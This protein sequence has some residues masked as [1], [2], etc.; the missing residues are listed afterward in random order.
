MS[1]HTT[2]DIAV[3]T[4]CS[5]TNIATAGRVLRHKSVEGLA[6]AW[7]LLTL[8]ACMSWT[9]YGLWQGNVF[10]V[11]TS[12]MTAAC[13]VVVL[14]MA[15]RAN[16]AKLWRSLLSTT[17]FLLV[18]SGMA[19]V[20]GANG[21]GFAGLAL[22]LINRIPQ[23]I[24]SLRTPGGHAVSLLGNG[25]DA[26]Q[27]LLWTVIAV[28]RYDVW[29]AASSLYCLLSAMF[30]VVRAVPKRAGVKSANVGSQP[31]CNEIFTLHN[32]QGATF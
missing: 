14:V 13:F 32:G 12:A 18:V 25:A 6:V 27:S 8:F 28:L 5:V 30:V 16:V 9:V 19:F 11:I 15:H 21:L 29:L 26:T 31:V 2:F 17:G 23:I 20:A 24:K 3:L 4:L 7:V 1:P 10:Q 22:T